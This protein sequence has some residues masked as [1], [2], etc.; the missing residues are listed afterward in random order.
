MKKIFKFLMVIALLAFVRPVNAEVVNADNEGL[1]RADYSITVNDKMEGSGFVAG[2][3]VNI[4]NEVDGILF[5]AGNFVN[6]TSKCDYMFVGG[7]A[8]N[9]NGGEFT[10]GFIAGQAVEIRDVKAARDLYV[11][12]S[13][14]KITGNVGR[15]LFIAGSDV[16]IDGVINGNVYI[17]AT[18]IT[19][20]SYTNIN[21]NLKYNED[22][23]LT[24]SKEAVIGSK[25]TYKS[26][27]SV[28]Y[29]G[30]DTMKGMIIN[31]LLNTLFNYLNM[32]V[33][34]LLMVLIIPRLFTKLREIDNNRL[35][36]SFAWGL[37]I[38]VAVPVAVLVLLFSYIGMS[39]AF[40]VMALYG[41]LVY[42]ATIFSTFKI[43][44]AILKEKVK[45]PYLVLLIG[46]TCLYLIKLLPFV[47]GLISFALICL[48]LGLLTNI[49]K[50]K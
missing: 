27:N 34:G 5:G 7:N 38:L 36:P 39:A 12:G 48:G 47:G 15:N 26:N 42:I 9:I 21:G 43:T 25:S 30:E 20:N 13:N 11:A 50:R 40:V 6:V 23:E 24:V 49:I 14:I 17:D 22:A 45:N 8:V 29:T 35:L 1:F 37:L 44:S 32:L 4:N 41:I 2:N 31:K 3:T 46:L 33:V 16:V 18:N 10:D 28:N 19:I